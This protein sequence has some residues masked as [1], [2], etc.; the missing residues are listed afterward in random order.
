MVCA[1]NF[2]HFGTAKE[3]REFYTWFE[4]LPHPHKMMVYGGHEVTTDIRFFKKND[5]CKY[6][7]PLEDVV[8]PPPPPSIKLLH[9]G[10]PVTIDGV[11]F[12]GHPGLG[13]ECADH[14]YNA[15]YLETEEEYMEMFSSCPP[16][17]DVLVTNQPPWWSIMDEV[18]RSKRPH[19]LSHLV[20][21]KIC[22]WFHIFGSLETGGGKGFGRGAR[23]YYNVSN[24]V[25]IIDF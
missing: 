12:W 5:F 19:L 20:D 21:Y 24:R 17:V 10:D 13:P 6:S 23:K 4:N 14:F 2:T 1:G 18:S 11:T 7:T 16:K 3:I 9:G 25:T 22:P 15:H 8:T